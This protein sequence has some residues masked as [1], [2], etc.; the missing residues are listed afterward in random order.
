MLSLYTAVLSISVPSLFQT[1]VT[2]IWSTKKSDT[3]EALFSTA[4]AVAIQILTSIQ[5]SRLLYIVG[6][7]GDRERGIRMLWQASRFSNVNGGMASLIL[8]GWYNGLIGFCDIVSDTDP[9]RPDDVEGYPAK[10]LENLLFEM[11]R[12]YPKS[13]LWIGKHQSISPG[14]HTGTSSLYLLCNHPLSTQI[15]RS[16]VWTK[17]TPFWRKYHCSMSF[18]GTT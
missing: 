8:F 13:H 14:P 4:T 12:R 3:D 6:F 5:F 1:H 9:S 11:R 18:G 7:R 10:R 2:A 16:Y 15:Y 17:A